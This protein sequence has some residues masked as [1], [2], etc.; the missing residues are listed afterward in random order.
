MKV[1]EKYQNHSKEELI[2]AAYQLGFDYEMHSFSC[3]QS[4]L[5]ALHE[6]I[7]MD[8]IVVKCATSSC[9]GSASETVGECGGYAGGLIALDY[10]FGRDVAHLSSTEIEKENVKVLNRALSIASE[11]YRKYMKKYGTIQCANIQQQ[12]FGRFYY[13]QDP[14]EIKK[15]NEQGAHTAPDKCCHIVGTAAE[16]LMEMLIEKGAVE[17]GV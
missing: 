11:Y 15:F 9:G 13:L 14:D 8:D 6:I 2:R 12:L 17:V 4:V 16:M 10:F 3:S 5:A 7:G 1:N